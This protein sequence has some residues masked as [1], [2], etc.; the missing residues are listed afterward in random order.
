MINFG[1]EISRGKTFETVEIKPLNNA[2]IV[3]TFIMRSWQRWFA[4]H[5]QSIYQHLCWAI[6]LERVQV[7]LFSMAVGLNVLINNKL[8]DSL[9]AESGKLSCHEAHVPEVKLKLF[10]IFLYLPAKQRLRGVR[11]KREFCITWRWCRI[12]IDMQKRCRV[13]STQTFSMTWKTH[14]TLT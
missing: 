8:I 3:I 12:S 14:S 11:R 9:I 6:L 5:L 10:I 7:K 4:I 13:L 2:Y 1:V